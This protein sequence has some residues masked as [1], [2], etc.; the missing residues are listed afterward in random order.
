MGVY[1]L[2]K[3]LRQN[4][5]QLSEPLVLTPRKGEKLHPKRRTVLVDAFAFWITCAKKL[6]EWG[7]QLDLPFPHGQ[8]RLPDAEYVR[9]LGGNLTALE[10][11]TK[12]LLN[13]LTDHYGLDLIFL[14]DGTRYSVNDKV[15]ELQDSNRMRVLDERNNKC[16]EETLRLYNFCEGHETFIAVQN[17]LKNRLP[18]VA[19]HQMQYTTRHCPGVRVLQVNGE[20]DTYAAALVKHFSADFFIS[21]DTDFVVISGIPT[22]FMDLMPL[23]ELLLSNAERLTLDVYS[24]THLCKVFKT[25][26]DKVALAAT[27]AGNDFTKSLVTSGRIYEG[28]FA[29]VLQTLIQKKELRSPSVTTLPL[30]AASMEQYLSPPATVEL[31]P[32]GLPPRLQAMAMHG[33]AFDSEALLNG[34]TRG[35]YAQL[36]TFQRTR[37]VLAYLFGLETLKVFTN[38]ATEPT[39][40]QVTLP[41]QLTGSFNGQPILPRYS[42]WKHLSLEQRLSRIAFIFCRQRPSSAARSMSDLF[43]SSVLWVSHAGLIGEQEL[44]LLASVM[45]FS[46]M[47]ANE[48]LSKQTQD[49]LM[50]C[51]E[52]K[53]G[54]SVLDQRPPPR[55]MQLAQIFT[56]SFSLVSAV[57]RLV[58]LDGT[59]S[60]PCNDAFLNP[61]HYFSGTVLHIFHL[62]NTSDLETFDF[63]KLT[64]G[65]A[66]PAIRRT[67]IQLVDNVEVLYNSVAV[68][69][70]EPL[71]FLISVD[72]AEVE[73][74]GS[75]L[76][77]AGDFFRD[78]NYV[79]QIDSMDGTTIPTSAAAANSNA[80]DHLQI[81]SPI[82]SSPTMP[83]APAETRRFPAEDH[84]GEVLAALRDHRVVCIQGDTGC[85]KSS[86]IPMQILLDAE[87]Q[88]SRTLIVVTQP[89]R[90][91]AVSL[92][93]RV[94][95]LLHEEVGNRVG[96][97]IGGGVRCE[98]HGVTSLLYVTTGYLLELL[99][100]GG[101][102]FFQRITHLILDEVHE[103]SIQAD[104]LSL[105]TKLTMLPSVNP[106]N[107]DEWN[108]SNALKYPIVEN[109]EKETKADV[110]KR[111]A[112]WSKAPDSLKETAT[113]LLIMSA[114]ISVDLFL[115]Y[116][117]PL[118][119]T[120]SAPVVNVGEKCFVVKEIYIDEYVEQLKN[121]GGSN[122][123]KHVLSAIEEVS[124]A[125]CSP[126]R[127]PDLNRQKFEG[128]CHLIHRA[129]EPGTC[130]LVF[131]PGLHEIEDMYFILEEA[132]RALPLRYRIH[133]V[134]SVIDGK[135]QELALT[136][137]AADECKIILATNIAET[138]LT[139]PD[140]KVV[141]DLGLARH[142]Y[143]DKKKDARVLKL[144]RCSRAS[145]R[146]RMGRAGRV[147]NGVVLRIY[148]KFIFE[149][150]MKAFDDSELYPLEYSVLIV[151]GCLSSYGSVHHVMQNLVEPPPS[152]DVNVAIQKLV[153]WGA[154]GSMPDLELTPFGSFAVRLP[155]EVSLARAI[156]RA[157]YCGCAAEMVVIAA[158]LSLPG[159]LIR[160][161]IRIFYRTH[162]EFQKAC[163]ETLN[164]M[165]HFDRGHRSDLYSIL[166]IYEEGQ[167]H[168]AFD[169]RCKFVQNNM[170]SPPNL[171]ALKSGASRIAQTVLSSLPLYDSE[172]RKSLQILS[173]SNSGSPPSNFKFRAMQSERYHYRL[174]LILAEASHMTVV[175]QTTS[176]Q[177]ESADSL[178]ILKNVSRSLLP[179]LNGSGPVNI[180]SSPLGQKLQ[181]IVP[182]KRITAIPKKS[183]C[184]V[185]LQ[186][187]P[188]AEM[189]AIL[190]SDLPPSLLPHPT[191][192]PTD[193]L[194]FVRFALM[195]RPR[196][197]VKLGPCYSFAQEEAPIDLPRPATPS[198][199]AFK[200]FIS[201]GRRVESEMKNSLMQFR[202]DFWSVLGLESA[203]YPLSGTLLAY[204]FNTTMNESRMYSSS[205][206]FMPYMAT[207]KSE[208]MRFRLL[209]ILYANLPQEYDLFTMTVQR[210]PI[211]GSCN[212]SRTPL[213][214]ILELLGVGCWSIADISL[215]LLESMLLSMLTIF[216]QVDPNCELRGATI[217]LMDAV[218]GI[219]IS[220]EVDDNV[221]YDENPSVHEIETLTYTCSTKAYLSITVWNIEHLKKLVASCR[222][223]ASKLT[224]NHVNRIFD[225]MCEAEELIATIDSL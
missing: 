132:K 136:P 123:P 106:G 121:G 141:I 47:L 168:L 78:I 144:C 174:Q 171:S 125:L 172:D 186:F 154:L 139:I 146:Q 35:S 8:E 58:V 152:Q 138:S 119:W 190:K 216:S 120:R 9:L 184:S 187:P 11:A 220:A 116:F 219:A 16:M 189:V 151:R 140:V 198:N 115:Q 39:V 203:S 223:G 24:C 101:D 34:K 217:D 10:A 213:S 56:E 88:S 129:A 98:K 12:K 4:K 68:D 17:D 114:T 30:V 113:R 50:Y 155:V 54:I 197:E 67:W 107:D 161:Q 131:L 5:E 29:D 158:G 133:A 84:I 77:T 91:A 94:S 96:Y 201:G 212:Y 209:S 206:G 28:D 156:H 205:F 57:F 62:L 72:S 179:P 192:L 188:D 38:K 43:A 165:C 33:I 64:F 48:Q 21:N 149:E 40:M 162:F 37:T 65:N 74:D 185:E 45:S 180:S 66:P 93:K 176:V 160:R 31:V 3:Y 122:C 175:V 169:R 110:A 27:L 196:E 44:C 46:S 95:S 204:V 163:F 92:A 71:N 208:D 103:R 178:V 135:E 89:R 128:I 157:T 130:V 182:L 181:A 225:C 143:Y 127:K 145:A 82:T 191:S 207:T 6:T 211:L 150:H 1:L 25:T 109:G 195:S 59:N 13:T 63:M 2:L 147:S 199:L 79:E 60:T 73:E 76:M 42:L 210:H 83:T 99:A 142:V 194:K 22:V 97:R 75:H 153:R 126:H 137:A 90:L 173:G 104:M 87:K 193:V 69:P 117:N 32:E 53:L 80:A 51:L 100:H 112:W 221:G 177:R 41:K 81:C 166:T 164:S 14:I 124:S 70:K 85:G 111:L 18:A 148:S 167:L 202:F 20:V 159:P 214:N 134:H 118:S 170:M 108:E 19:L 183:N 52:S 218:R 222:N 15:S 49:L 26:P 200:G 36:P 224:R 55:L 86:I 102:S 61:S 215:V 7:D 23:K 105:V